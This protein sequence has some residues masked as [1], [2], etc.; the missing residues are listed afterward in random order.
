M[1]QQKLRHWIIRE[2]CS[3]HWQGLEPGWLVAVGNRAAARSIRRSPEGFSP[4]P[5]DARNGRC[6]VP[7]ILYSVGTSNYHAQPD[8]AG[9]WTGAVF[10]PSWRRESY[11]TG[12]RI[13]PPAGGRYWI[14]GT[15][16]YVP[17]DP[18]GKDLLPVLE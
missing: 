3:F 4:D 2:V 12:G 10:R 9:T 14:P 1:A 8:R 16:P 13:P 11:L 6:G 15:G 18:G 7:R 17:P 5:V